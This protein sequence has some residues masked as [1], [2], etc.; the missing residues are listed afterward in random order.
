MCNWMHFEYRFIFVQVTSKSKRHRFQTSGIQRIFILS[1][2]SDNVHAGVV[3]V[4]PFTAE[5]SIVSA[6]DDLADLLLPL[7]AGRAAFT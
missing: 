6:K 4:E 1:D 5:W 2:W 3:E 7:P